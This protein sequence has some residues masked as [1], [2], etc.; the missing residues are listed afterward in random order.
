MRCVVVDSSP[1]DG[2]PISEAILLMIDDPDHAVRM[3]MAK[4]V[5]SL[6]LVAGSN[7]LVSREEQVQF[8]HQV[9]DMVKKA[10]LISVSACLY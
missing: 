4:V 5:T 7:Q 6:H 2:I 8:F 10:H 1:T 9:L 3:H